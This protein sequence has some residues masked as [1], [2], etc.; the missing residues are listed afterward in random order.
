MS[1]PLAEMS[2]YV[3]KVTAALKDVSLMFFIQLNP[4]T[5]LGLNMCYICHMYDMDYF[6]NGRFMPPF[7]DIQSLPHK[8]RF[9]FQ[10]G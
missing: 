3:A 10:G 5:L 2:L 6:F 9:K 8:N 7:R 4:S 1:L